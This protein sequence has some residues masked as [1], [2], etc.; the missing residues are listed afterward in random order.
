MRVVRSDDFRD[1][2]DD[3]RQRDAIE[4]RCDGDRSVNR[5]AAWSIELPLG[6]GTPPRIDENVSRIG[7]PPLVVSL[8][9]GSQTISRP[10]FFHIQ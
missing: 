8:A 7:K 10:S 6:N 2:D 4:K 1:R 3:R 5:T 9:G